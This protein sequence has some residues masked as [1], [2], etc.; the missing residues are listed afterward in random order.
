MA[1]IFRSERGLQEHPKL[2]RSKQGPISVESRRV[3]EGYTDPAAGSLGSVELLAGICGEKGIDSKG[4]EFY[5]FPDP[6]AVA[7]LTEKDLAECRL[8]YRCKYVHAAAEA[9]LHQ[10]IELNYLKQA[11]KEAAMEA[12]AGLYGVGVKVANCVSL[13]SLHH[14]DA[15]PID[16]WMKRILK[17]QYPSGYPYEKYSPYNGIFQPYMFAYYRHSQTK[18]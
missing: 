9:V 16:V 18:S 4:Q 15:F 14:T 17:E 8:G 7:G 12:R 11:D 10:K 6:E 1:G 13:F 2:H 3:R 5:A